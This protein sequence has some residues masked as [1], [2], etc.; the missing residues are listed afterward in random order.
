MNVT[1]RIWISGCFV[2]DSTAARIVATAIF[3]SFLLTGPASAQEE[4]EFSEGAVACLK[5]H[6]SDKVMAIRKTPHANFE[7]PKSPASREQCESCHGPSAKHMRYPM[8]VGNIVFTKHGKTPI[9]DRNDSCL[10]CHHKGEQAHWSNGAHAKKLPCPS[11]HVIHKAKDPMMLEQN[12]AQECGKCHEKI[13]ELAPV[14]SSHPLLGAK[15]IVCTQ[16]HNPHGP[17]NLATCAT[18]HTQDAPTLAKQTAKAQDY[19][20]RGLK[21]K[22]DCTDCHKGFVHAMPPLE[23]EQAP[24]TP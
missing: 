2:L 8:Q 9:T 14:A 16:C 1:N 18:C 4:G 20:A 21:Q 17:T 5:C 10:A 19:H 6:E 11:C 22:I 15:G 13:L 3:L 12:R 7:D 24:G 23:L